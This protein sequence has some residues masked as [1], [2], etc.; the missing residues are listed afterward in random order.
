MEAIGGSKNDNMDEGFFKYV[1][2]FN[3]DNKGHLLNL[4]QYTFIG[5]PLIIIIL[6]VMNYYTPEEDDTKG[7]LVIVVEICTSISIILLSIWFINKIIMPPFFII[8]LKP[9][10]L[11]QR[12]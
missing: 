10:F 3:D 8:I 5:V 4:F 7:T 1:F 12:L 9:M 6:K 11:H 2:N